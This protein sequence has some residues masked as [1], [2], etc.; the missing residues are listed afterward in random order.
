MILALRPYHQAQP[1]F[2]LKLIIIHSQES[3][4]TLKKFD[5]SSFH[6]ATPRTAAHSEASYSRSR[7]ALRGS[8]V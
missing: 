3:Q 7:R 6:R 8:W 5:K 4:A 2:M 1:V